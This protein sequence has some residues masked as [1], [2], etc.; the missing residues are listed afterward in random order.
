[1]VIGKPGAN[2]RLEDAPF[3]IA[4]YA[5]ALDLTARDL[6]AQAKSAGLPWS[7]A[8]GY[9]TFC[10]VSTY[11]PATAI[12]DPMNQDIWLMVNGEVRQKTNTSDMIFS[13]YELISRLSRVMRLEP[14]DFLLTGTP[15][16]VGPLQVGDSV[17]AGLG[18]DYV[19]MRYKCVPKPKALKS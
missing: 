4:G 10:P 8:K 19:E 12:T 11:I 5:V 9:D 1:M 18:H 14:G 16:G 17:K 6:Q 7:I 2:I 3:H 15:S 13:V